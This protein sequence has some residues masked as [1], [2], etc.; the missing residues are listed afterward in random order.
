MER[1]FKNINK[2]QYEGPATSNHLAFRHYNADEIVLGKRLEEHLRFAVAFWHNFAWEGS[3]PFGG[4]TFQRP[5][6]PQTTLE[7]AKIKLDAAFDMFDILGVPYFCFHDAD[8][9]PEM[10]NF[11]ENLAAFEAVIAYC[12]EKM[13][14]RKVG[15]LWGT[16]NMFT[17]RRWM[18]GAATNPDPD[19]FAYAAATV[20]SCLDATHKMAGEN[21]VLWGGREGYETLLNTD[22]GKEIDQMGRFLSMVV[23]YK[24]KIGFQGT[25]LLEPKPQEPSK[26][27]YDFDVATCFGFLQKYGLEKEVK[28]NIE[29]GHAIL[30][31]HSFE[32]EIA[33]AHALGVFGSIDMNR[34]DY[35]SGWDTDQFPHNIPE[36]ALA[37]YYI[38]K[39]GGFT[40]GGTNFDTKIRR[41]SIDPED[42][43]IAHIGA[44]DVCAK[45]LKVAAKM[46]EDGGL[47]NA[48]QARYAKWDT[49]EAQRFLKSD[50]DTLSTHVMQN[51]I[52]P[53][54][55]SGKQELLENYV[56][57]FL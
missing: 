7:Q 57:R 53:T 21:Y 31:G 37:Y 14:A 26:H 55:V 30:A 54:P 41:Q 32:H 50:L 51:D 20:K 29:Q 8:I 3:D 4:A 38:L 11:R 27:Q 33:L 42:L 52:N 6:F 43:I 1:F 49:P 12:L 22:L 36:V 44:M 34:N 28:L 46:I 5:W 39:G 16:A 35:Q 23:D 45:A 40:T 15:L 9:R 2:V 47:E 18:A 10:G 24:H 56:N 19:M 48:L 25:I 13:A 17:H